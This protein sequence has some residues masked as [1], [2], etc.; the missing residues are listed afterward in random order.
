LRLW[1]PRY[2]S[3][4]IQIVEDVIDDGETYRQVV[5]TFFGDL[6]W[7]TDRDPIDP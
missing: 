3:K 2:C 6:E 5:G 1:V 4:P 7:A